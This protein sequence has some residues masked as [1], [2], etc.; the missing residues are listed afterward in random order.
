VKSDI[1]ITCNSSFSTVASYF[2]YNKPT[3]YHPHVFFKGIS[4]GNYIPTDEFGNF[5]TGLLRE[6]VSNYRKN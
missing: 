1:L 3:I 4:S 5:D 2:R 6:F